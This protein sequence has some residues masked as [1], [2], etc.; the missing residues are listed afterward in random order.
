MFIFVRYL[1]FIL[2]L[3]KLNYIVYWIIL[4]RLK[5]I[6]KY[7]EKSKF[8]L[9]PGLHIVGCK[10]IFLKDLI[11]PINSYF[12]RPDRVLLRRLKRKKKNMEKSIFFFRRRV[13]ISAGCK[14]IFLKDLKLPIN[15]YFF[16]LDRVILRRLKKIKKNKR[17]TKFFFSSTGLHIGRM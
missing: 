17:K 6:K 16:R 13:C 7:M 4:S 1:K 15:S 2:K 8:F 9:S 5:K 3:C 10:R 14:R 12:C 11:L